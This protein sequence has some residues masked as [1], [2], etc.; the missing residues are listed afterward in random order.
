MTRN[1][2]AA[3]AAATGM[4]L[5]AGACGAPPPTPNLERGL[6]V[7]ATCIPCHGQDGLGKQ[8][9]GAPAIAGHEAWYIEEQLKKFRSGARGWHA[10][11][12][13]GLRMK[14]MALSIPRDD[15]VP[16]VAAYVA[17]LKPP[18]YRPRVTGGDPGRGSE[19]FARCTACHGAGAGGNP[20]LKAP[21]LAGKDD[22]YL[23]NQLKKF[24]AGI[25]GGGSMDP[26]G[27]IMRAQAAQL[28]DEQAMK[29][30][31]SHIQRLTRP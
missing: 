16:A 22:W 9:L 5:A 15:D 1:G 4:A 30:V 29:D 14:P 7:Y 10:E 3:L 8:E 26:N 19:Q 24:K 11:D 23:L 6:T 27:M 17:S 20:I 13:E 2:M 12:L 28:P 21:A 31:I 18:E 25:R